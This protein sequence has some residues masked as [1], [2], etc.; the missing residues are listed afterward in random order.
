[1]GPLFIFIFVYVIRLFSFVQKSDL[2]IHILSLRP[3]STDSKTFAAVGGSLALRDIQV[4]SNVRFERRRLKPLQQFFEGSV[5]G[6]LHEIVQV[7]IQCTYIFHWLSGFIHHLPVQPLL[8]DLPVVF[9]VNLL[10][11]PTHVWHICHW[12]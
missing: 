3:F 1:M 10:F 4:R 8:P 11:C 12:T 2:E 7:P 6:L 5:R 9:I